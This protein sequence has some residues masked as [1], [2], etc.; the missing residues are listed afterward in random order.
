MDIHLSKVMVLSIDT[1]MLTR[2]QYTRVLCFLVFALLA[3]VVEAEE[4]MLSD[5]GDKPDG[6]KE[7]QGEPAMAATSSKVGKSATKKGRVKK[8]LMI[9]WAIFFVA[10]LGGMVFAIWK[11]VCVCGCVC[12]RVCVGICVGVFI[13]KCM[14]VCMY[15]CMYV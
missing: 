10:M 15:A 9:F 12:L 13:Y 2:G 14:Y 11:V 3:F 8:L 7:V 4:N 1:R 5:D 6:V